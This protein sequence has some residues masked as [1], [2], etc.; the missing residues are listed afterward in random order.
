VVVVFREAESAEFGSKSLRAR[1]RTG[2][3]R[4][5]SAAAALAFV[6]LGAGG[7]AKAN[8]DPGQAPAFDELSLQNLLDLSVDVAL[9]GAG[10]ESLRHAPAVVEVVGAA[11]IERWGYRTVAEA[12]SH[13]VGFYFVDDHAVP[14]V[15]VRGVSGGVGGEAGTVKVLIDGRAVSFRP[16]SGSW[17]GVE[18]VPLSAVER[19]EIIR[20]PGSAMYGAD[21]FLGVVNVVTQDPGS[22]G[23]GNVR[24][25]AGRTAGSFGRTFDGSF[26]LKAG[27]WGALVGFATD[28]ADR[29]SLPLPPSSPAPRVP[30]YNRTARSATGLAR[31]ST[32]AYG[33]VG[34]ASERTRGLRAFT[35]AAHH[36]RLFRGG[37]FSRWSHLAHGSDGQGRAV[38]SAISL[39]RASLALASRW[40]LADRWDATLSA[41]YFQGGS[42]DDERIEVN[43]D[44]FFVKR[45][46]AF[47]GVEAQSELLWNTA[48]DLGLVL[49]AE[50]VY[51]DEEIG[52]PSRVLKSSGA[53][54]ATSAEPRHKLGNLGAYLQSHLKLR[55]GQLRLTGG[56][57]LDQHFVYGPQLTGRVAAVIA[58]G[59]AL[60]LKLLYG[61]A[62]KAPSPQLLYSTPLE[63]GGLVGNADLKPQFVHTLEAHASYQLD[64][65]MHATTGVAYGLV[66]D[67]AEFVAQGTNQTAKNI[68][69][70]QTLSWET[71]IDAV[72]RDA[73]RGYLS[74]DFQRVFRSIGQGDYFSALV[75]DKGG[76]APVWLVRAGASRR[77]KTAAS[78]ALELGSEIRVVGP[79]S[80]S[81]SNIL[82]HGGLYH[83]GTYVD[84]GASLALTDLHLFGT[85]KSAISLRGY[86]LLGA[87]TA[88]PGHGGVDYPRVGREIYL[89]LRQ[90]F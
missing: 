42:R 18:L 48:G 67:K 65:R 29:S 50:I 73:L 81:D 8:N 14:D 32:S 12:L 58:L 84:L 60:V 33:K 83:L 46:L 4:L 88:D 19:I 61:S 53:V 71:R 5:K 76:D 27:A 52:N 44:L 6:L 63:P 22:A 77:W 69:R 17:L 68:A 75:A 3:S 72:I 70:V 39:E 35:L 86:D 87:A 85:R 13:I 37:D 78:Y 82:E 16:T 90:E 40:R 7:Q 10:K 89:D 79:R 38:G 59:E 11:D 34:Y 47:R 54:L 49:G 26:R 9:A 23:H 64:E 20:G 51:D 31:R 45:N 24:L 62:F 30:D 25:L 36:A 74:F 80:A 2:Q 21:A 66:L 15:A 41:E 28:E 1:A 56:L 57:R 43:S 55:E